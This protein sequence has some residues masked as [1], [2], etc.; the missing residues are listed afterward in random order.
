MIEHIYGFLMVVVQILVLPEYFQVVYP[1]IGGKKIKPVPLVLHIRVIDLG[2]TVPDKALHGFSY[3]SFMYRDII[4]DLVADYHLI[5]P[6]YPGFGL[7]RRP[8]VYG[9][10]YSFDNMAAVMEDFYRPN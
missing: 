6:D 2:I 10:D 5:A 8:P 3:S 7:S 4:N 1:F 9:F